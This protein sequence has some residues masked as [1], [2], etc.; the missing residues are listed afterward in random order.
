MPE[1]AEMPEVPEL[2]DFLA[3]VRVVF[4]ALERL[5][6][7][8]HTGTGPGLPASSLQALATARQQ[9]EPHTMETPSLDTPL[10]EGPAAAVGAPEAAVARL[11]DTCARPAGVAPCVP[12]GPPS[13]WLP[14]P[15]LPGC[16]WLSALS[17]VPSF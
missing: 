3:N 11:F 14:Q 6:L 17:H 16:G 2:P 5:P 8:G 9:M 15:W 7:A 4:D 12:P 1:E 13:P 10:P